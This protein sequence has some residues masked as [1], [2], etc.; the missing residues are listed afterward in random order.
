MFY[1]SNLKGP[2]CGHFYL[3]SASFDAEFAGDFMV[4]TPSLSTLI[5]FRAEAISCWTSGH[6]SFSSD[7]TCDVSRGVGGTAV[8]CCKFKD[9]VRKWNKLRNDVKNVDTFEQLIACIQS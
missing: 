1:I 9:E 5:S 3:F 8:Y 6:C 4:N 2:Y 7:K